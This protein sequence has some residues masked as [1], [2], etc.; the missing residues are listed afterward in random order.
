LNL[1]ARSLAVGL[2]LGVIIG[3]LAVVSFSGTLYP[4]KPQYMTV[5]ETLTSVQTSHVTTTLTT[6]T[7]TTS[8]CGGKWL[9]CSDPNVISWQDAKNYEGKTKTVEGTIV[10]TYRSGTNTVYLNFRDPYQGYFYAVIFS[11]DLK[12]FP[13]KPEDFYKGKEVR[14]TGL[15]QMYQGSPEIIVKN[16]SQIEVANMGFNYP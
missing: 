4:P 8:D 2:L 3:G 12:N 6:C 11:S 5:T 1:E 9:V 15:V 13:F 10:R 16:P 7:T 14:V